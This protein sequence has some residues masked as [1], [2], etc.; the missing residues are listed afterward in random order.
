MAAK[1]TPPMNIKA[2]EQVRGGAK[3]ASLKKGRAYDV[4][5]DEN[6]KTT[7]VR[8][9]PEFARDLKICVA[10]T[11]IPQNQYIIESV[12]IRMAKDKKEIAK[13]YNS[14]K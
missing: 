9:S 8:M 10:H 11:D 5:P 6:Y 13:R 4:S 14:A 3:P 2:T 7:S 12:A 1:P